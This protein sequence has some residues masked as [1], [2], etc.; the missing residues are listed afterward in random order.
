MAGKGSKIPSIMFVDDLS[1]FAN[2]FEDTL[3]QYEAVQ[4]FALSHRCVINTS[5]SKIATTEKAQ[6]LRAAMEEAGLPMDITESYISLGAKYKL[7]HIRNHK[8]AVPAT[9]HRLSKHEP[10][11]QK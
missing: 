9:M 8:K 3:Q 2:N 6:E 5:K 4:N 1:T 11:L 7:D 10:C